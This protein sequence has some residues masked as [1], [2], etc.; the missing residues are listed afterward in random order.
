M[1]WITADWLLV[2]GMWSHLKAMQALV[3]VWYASETN[4]S[5]RSPGNF[6]HQYWPEKLVSM[7]VYH[8]MVKC[9]SYCYVCEARFSQFQSHFAFW[10]ILQ[11]L[12]ILCLKIWHVHANLQLIWWHLFSSCNVN[13][14]LSNSQVTNFYKVADHNLGLLIW[15]DGRDTVE[16]VHQQHAVQPNSKF[17]TGKKLYIMSS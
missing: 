6:P 7:Y 2:K 12:N 14:W 16:D 17:T 1:W 3:N 8:L 10:N 5:K 15:L 9:V 13:F 4:H 11:T